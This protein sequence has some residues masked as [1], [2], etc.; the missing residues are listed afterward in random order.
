VAYKG[1][2]KSSWT[3][4]LEWELKM[5][6]FSVTRCNFITILRVNLVS[7]AAITLCVTSQWMFIVVYFIIDSVRKHLDAPSYL[8]CVRDNS[9]PV[10]VKCC[11]CTVFFFHYILYINCKL[12]YGMNNDNSNMQQE[13]Y[14]L[15]RLLELAQWR[16]DKMYI[17]NLQNA[18]LTPSVPYV[19]IVTNLQKLQ[20]Q[21]Q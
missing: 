3:G 1:V 6:Q 16:L 2:S 7:F 12:I 21:K 4:C 5:V 20:F 14:L 15:Y 18:F 10:D 9:W 11:R 8:S 19:N 13:W 17:Y